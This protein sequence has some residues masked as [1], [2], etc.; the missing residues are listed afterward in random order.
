MNHLCPLITHSSPSLIACVLINVGSEPATSGSVMAKHDDP[1]PSQSGFRYCCFCSSVAQCS[2]VCMLPSSGAW[3]LSTHGPTRVLA[4]SACTIASAT[5]PSP[6]PPHSGGMCG[7]QSPAAIADLRKPISALDVL[8][9]G[10]ALHLLPVP[11][12]LDHR[13]D[14]V[15]DEGAHTIADLLVL[16]CE[17][18]VN[19]HLAS[20]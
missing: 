9:S 8:A 12:R 19:G 3:Q 18:E 13:L 14:R 20:P 15:L 6:M 7:S 5:W 11:E 10:V 1:V 2:S 4:A 16:R 17:R